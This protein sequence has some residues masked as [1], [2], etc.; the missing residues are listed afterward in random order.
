AAKVVRGSV[1]GAATEPSSAE[2]GRSVASVSPARSAPPGGF[3]GL[4]KGLPYPVR[5]EVLGRFG[6]ERPE[7]GLWRGIVLRSPEGTAVQAVAAGRVVYANWLSGF[8][9]IMIVDHGAKYLSVYA[10]N[11]SLL[12]RVGDIV[13]AGDTI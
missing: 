3:T 2:A 7:G 4:H 8:G 9:N 12:K 5:G 11:Q 1:S 6:A 10:Y 13:A